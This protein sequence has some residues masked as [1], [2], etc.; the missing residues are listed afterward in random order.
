MEETEN[1]EKNQNVTENY[2]HIFFAPVDNEAYM[3]LT[4]L[5]ILVAFV[6][7]ALLLHLALFHVYI[8]HVGITTYEY[9]RAHRL[10][11]EQM[12]VNQLEQELTTDS[13]C[14]QIF[15]KI[16]SKV[17]PE[18]ATE[19]QAKQ[20]KEIPNGTSTVKKS[21]VDEKLP[22]IM[23]TPPRKIDVIPEEEPKGSNVPKLPKLDNNGTNGTHQKRAP[24]LGK[25]HK[26]LESVDFEDQDKIYVVEVS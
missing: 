24:Q 25:I 16:T 3:G 15:K 9:V 21:I 10:A 8:N 17:S 23:L 4:I 18:Q 1:N 26:H 6:A 12:S 19:E 20:T 13:K 5:S 14:C 7:F 11:M 22:P 2:F